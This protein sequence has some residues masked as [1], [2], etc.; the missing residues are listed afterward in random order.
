ML[1]PNILIADDQQDVLDSLRLMLKSDDVRTVCVRSPAAA[2]KALKEQAFD[3]ALIDLN[4]TRDTTSGE[5]GLQLLR[6]LRE[7]DGNLPVIAMTA[8]G[9]VELAVEAMRQGAADFIE[10]PWEEARLISVLRNQVAL[11]QALRHG[12]KLDEENAALR[13]RGIDFV[14]ESP[15]MREVLHLASQVAGADAGVLV[16][17][18]NGTGKGVLARHIHT[19]SARAAEP[20]IRVNLGGLAESL[21]ESELFGHVKGAFT[22]AKSDRLGRF[23][24]ADGGTLF[25]DEIGNLT[26]DQQARLLHVLEEGEFERVGASRPIRVDVRIV[27]ATNVDLPRAIDNGHFRKD[28]YYRLNTVR[29]ELPPLREREQDIAPLAD[30]FLARYARRYGKRIAALTPDASAA[31]ARYRWP[32]NVRELQHV[33]ERAVLLTQSETLSASDLRLEADTSVGNELEKMTLDD[34][35]QFLIRAALGRSQ[36]NVNQAAIELGMS[37]SALYRRLQRFGIKA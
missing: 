14:A 17:G 37:R 7:L 33:M 5:E 16:T 12:R 31:L 6:A 28:L 36:G 15:A 35:D 19:L 11:G 18:E 32:G 4:Y 30:H 27:S 21:F 8:W 13:G 1:D 29:I 3:A 20:F 9:S 24:L 22:D 25:L 34:A 23:E 2:L 26:M 10:K